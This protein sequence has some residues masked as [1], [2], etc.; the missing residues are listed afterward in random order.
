[1]PATVHAAQP[2]D[3]YRG[4]N[5]HLLRAVPADAVDLLEVGC[6]EGRL[7]AALKAARPGRRVVGV[8]IAAA[9]A[10]RAREVLDAVFEL[11]VERGDP[12]LPAASMDCIL[13]GDVLEHLRDPEA[14]LRRFGRFLRP[15][16]TILCCLP[17]AQ[18]VSVLASLLRGEFQY[19]AAGILD[20]THLRFFTFAS[21][22]K[23]LLDAGFAPAL[24]DPIVTA[25]DEPFLQRLQPVIAYLG[26]NVERARAAMSCYQYVLRGTPLGWAP[27]VSPEE[28][29]SFVSCV[30]DEAVLR[31][32]LLAS[33]CFQGDSPHQLVLV[34]GARSAAEGLN[35]G[36]E[37]AQHDTVVL[38]HQD[39]YL[40]RGWPARFSEQVSRA[41]ESLGDVAV[42]GLFGARRCPA[43]PDGVE[44]AGHVL[45][46][47]WLRRQGSLPAG[48]ETVDELLIAVRRG[49]SL[50]FD[51]SL[52]FHLY[53][54]D[55][56]CAARR[57]G[58]KVA[59]VDACC[60]HNSQQGGALPAAFHESAEV[61]RAKWAADLPVATCC[62]LMSNGEAEALRS[63]APT[64]TAGPDAFDPWAGAR[65]KRILVVPDV[66][67]DADCWAAVFP[68]LAAQ[69]SRQPDLTLG[70]ALPLE[71]VQK[72]P[73]PV[74]ALSPALDLDLLLIERPSSAAGWESLLRGTSIVV[75][76]AHQPELMDLARRLRVTVHDAVA[77]P[78]LW[79]QT[80]A[81]APAIPG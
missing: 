19:Q 60:F 12:A 16:G 74:Q 50:R 27:A 40:P 73:P 71:H 18:H 70:V 8:E 11:D 61:F 3:Y 75:R 7:G 33:P 13:F 9:A 59:V 22:C 51:P 24:V 4:L 37:R 81:A 20:A 36:L 26:V 46:R 57:A 2:A 66:G 65:G 62:A 17:N 30:N 1:M 44:R 58:Q 78:D 55:I 5:M 53:G 41:R 54:S 14:V 35:G 72:L 63:S 39:V 28:P 77:D 64:P 10:A 56:A 34:R 67:S 25:P 79:P 23:L 6:A 38:V 48:V 15:G 47:E 76:T 31:D 29:L 49:T 68:R 80:P 42:T 32:N 43:A 45:D 21:A 52:G 69:L